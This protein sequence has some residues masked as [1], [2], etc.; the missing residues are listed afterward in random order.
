M[1]K[2]L[3]Y[4]L[5]FIITRYALALDDSTSVYLKQHI[6][7]LASDALE[8]RKAGSKGAEL[9][10]L[11]IAKQFS[12]C[13]LTPFGDNGSYF[14]NFTFIAGVKLGEKHSLNSVEGGNKKTYHIDKDYRPLAFSA[15]GDVS[16]PVVF[17][18]YGISS[19]DPQYR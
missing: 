7:Y 3:L 1:K 16:G 14:Q 4:S 6:G 13:G 5:L 8:G 19:S 15:N 10:A 9:A 17:A 18:G 2:I 12:S 11:Y